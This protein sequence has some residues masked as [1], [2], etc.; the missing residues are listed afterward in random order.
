MCYTLYFL[1]SMYVQ[2][3]FTTGP[4]RVGLGVCCVC[5]TKIHYGVFS[6]SVYKS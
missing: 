6:V 4:I 3:F 1:R 2:R 5:V